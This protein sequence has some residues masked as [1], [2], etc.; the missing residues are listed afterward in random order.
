MTS[1][2]ASLRAQG[3]LFRSG[4][5]WVL[6]PGREAARPGDLTDDLTDLI[7]D[8]LDELAPAELDVLAAV[9]VWGED[10]TRDMIGA[11]VADDELGQRLD[12]LVEA[13]LVDEYSQRHRDLPRPPLARR[14]GAPARGCPPAQRR[15]QHAAAARHLLERPGSSPDARMIA[16]HVRLAGPAFDPARALDVLTAAA[17][18]DSP[19]RSG[20]ETM[21]LAEATVALIRDNG[22]TE[23]LPAAL[24]RMADAAALAGQTPDAIAAWRD[25]VAAYGPDRSA[26]ARCRRRLALLLLEQG[27]HDGAQRALDEA[28]AAVLDDPA[29]TRERFRVLQLRAT[30]SLRAADRTRFRQ[31]VAALRPAAEQVG[32]SSV[33]DVFER[34]VN[35]G[36]SRDPPPPAPST[37]LMA[38]A[39]QVAAS[40]AE[41]D[42]TMVT[43]WHRPWI[44]D[45]IA[46]G[47]LAEAGRR[48]RQA[49]EHS[50]AAP[51]TFSAAIALDAF[52]EVARRRVDAGF[53][54]HR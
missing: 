16:H 31:D 42:Q 21:L 24:E 38:I 29:S 5:Q 37:D 2:V 25:A 7:A 23:L 50:A 17:D 20:H 53:P 52:R 34:Y 10:A 28:L 45:A 18:T 49:P 9:G 47:E 46:R 44:V 15:L 36:A 14:R 39:G 30:F 6:A 54:A 33:A 51:G 43:H 8:R 26:A 32:L 41:D 11:L 19:D 12:R 1:L 48:V 35:A 40:L 4:G 27:D 3:H 13:G 22:R